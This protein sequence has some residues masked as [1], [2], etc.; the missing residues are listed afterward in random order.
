MQR[1]SFTRDGLELSYLDSGAGDGSGR[2]VV[3]L[4]GHLM[5]AVTFEP[6]ASGLTSTGWRVVALDQRGHGHS[7]HAG[8][9]T[10][11]DHLGDLL[12]FVD[13]LGL[14][15]AVFLGHSLGGVNAYQ[16]AVRHPERVDGLVIEDIGAEV[17][18]GLEF[19]LP[20]AGTYP[21]EQALADRLGERFADY[22]R[23]SFRRVDGG[24]TLAFEPAEMVES[25]KNLQG[26]HWAD[27][28]AS[29]CPAL[30]VRGIDSAVTI[31]DDISDMA[32]RRPHTTMVILP[33]GHTVHVDSPGGY[34]GE[35]QRFLDG[36]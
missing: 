7:Q 35:V 26:D 14:D 18:T 11:D 22:F 25:G 36:I 30:V 9:Y 21:T 13:H 29:S 24:W 28:L 23:A 4:H 5:E 16:F 3:A 34:L 19:C 8:S 6:L 12:A 1:A 31:H 33:G 17:T 10:R 2:V 20:W 15:R 32:L 27:W